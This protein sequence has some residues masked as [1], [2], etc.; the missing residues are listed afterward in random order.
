MPQPQTT[1]YRT[2]PVSQGQ[3]AIVDDSDYAWLCQWRWHAHWNTHTKSFYVVRGLY[4]PKGSGMKHEMI[5]MH[6]FI[7]NAPRG[8]YVDHVNHNTL[9]NRR[10]N[11][12]LCTPS[13]NQ[14][15]K[16]KQ[17]SNKSGVVGVHQS[18][19]TGKWV[20]QIRVDNQVL[21]LGGYR[22]LEE[23][24]QVR[25]DA[26]VKFHRDFRLECSDKEEQGEMF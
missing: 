15:N 8:M 2:I 26:E 23:A 22:T 13:Q 1:E 12:R 25:R 6:R 5:R 11:L 16:R 10:A 20:V 4:A 17:K 19:R 14:Q 21:S 3:F 9:D 7:M 18:K 24:A